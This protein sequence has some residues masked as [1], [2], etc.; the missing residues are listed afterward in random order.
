MVVGGLGLQIHAVPDGP[1][2]QQ[3]TPLFW[4]NQGPESVTAGTGSR[5]GL[6]GRPLPPVAPPVSRGQGDP[7]SWGGRLLAARVEGTWR[8]VGDGSGTPA[9]QGPWG[10]PGSRGRPGPPSGGRGGLGRAARPD[11]LPG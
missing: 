10:P 4:A 5:A 11:A 2:H 8:G 6:P 7:G 9:G 3:P 1:L